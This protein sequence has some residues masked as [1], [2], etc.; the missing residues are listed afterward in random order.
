MAHLRQGANLR[1]G[2]EARS[3]QGLVE[4]HRHDLEAHSRQDLEVPHRPG[5]VG[6]ACRLPLE[7]VDPDLQGLD[8]VVEE[9]FKDDRLAALDQDPEDPSALWCRRPSHPRMLVDPDQEPLLVQACNRDLG[10]H[11]G[12]ECRRGRACHQ[13]QECHPDQECHPGL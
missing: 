12:R 10:W 11:P 1:Q 13:G 8:L 4:P 3:R 7:V 2:L 6:G 9:Q 5:L